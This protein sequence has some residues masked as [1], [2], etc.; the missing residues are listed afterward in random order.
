MKRLEDRPWWPELVSLKDTL[1]LRELAERFGAAPAAIANALRRNN[2]DR[3]PAPPGPRAY[4]D[5]AWRAAADAAT[6]QVEAKPVEAPKAEPSKA[7]KAKAE[8]SSAKAE[9]SSAKAEKA[10]PVKAAQVEAAPAKAAKASKTSSKAA[11]PAPVE[12]PAVAVEAPAV[13]AEAPTVVEVAATVEAEPAA[14]RKELDKATPILYMS[15]MSPA[16]PAV[17][18]VRGYRAVINGDGYVI[19]ASNVAEAATIA[20]NAERGDVVSI[21]LLGL[22]L[23]L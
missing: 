13:V 4:R 5:P 7:E 22:A 11:K 1:S 15:A 14:P 20:C 17:R 16:A 6:A 10:A 18:Q 23:A 21:E 2:L 19:V 12:A 9:K 3:A 8:K